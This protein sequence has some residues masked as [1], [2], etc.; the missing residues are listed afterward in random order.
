MSPEVSFTKFTIGLA[1]ANLFLWSWAGT[2]LHQLET[3]FVR[4]DIIP[5]IALMLAL[6]IQ[7]RLVLEVRKLEKKSSV[8]P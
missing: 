7:Y 3:S 4:R 8:A 5:G 6:W 2:A 1:T